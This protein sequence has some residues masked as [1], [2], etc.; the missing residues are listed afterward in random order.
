MSGLGKAVPCPGYGPEVLSHRVASPGDGF[1]PGF[2]QI[3]VPCP[4]DYETFKHLPN[5]VEYDGRLFG[6]SCFDSDHHI[7]VY[8][9]SHVLKYTKVV[10]FLPHG[11]SQATYKRQLRRS[12]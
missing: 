3:T 12:L 6:K 7:A 4:D 9:T 10:D 1:P 11:M 2:E 8:L 5:V